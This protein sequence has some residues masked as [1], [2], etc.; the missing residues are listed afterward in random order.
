PAKTP[1]T[2]KK[3]QA[4]TAQAQRAEYAQD[5]F[6]ELN[7]S[8]FDGGLPPD[9][10]LVWSNRL[11][12]TAGRARWHRSKDGVHTTQIELA[13]KVLD[14]NERIRNTLSHEMC[15]LAC[16]IINKDPKEGHGNAFKAWAAKVMRRRPEIEITT[17]HDYE[18]SYPYEWECGDCAKIYGRFSKSI[19]PDEV[20]CGACKT[21]KLQAL[22]SVRARATATP[23]T[24]VKAGSK[25]ASGTPRG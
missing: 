9:T 25:L 19:R 11:L 15:H 7:K 4:Q 18:I 14:S 1:R 8:V 5:L 20:V 17:R 24:K 21:G 16:W 6:N 13:T 22:F 3:A 12:T 23:K 2:S 10:R